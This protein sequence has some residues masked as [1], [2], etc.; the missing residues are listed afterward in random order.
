VSSAADALP[1]RDAVAARR[2][3]AADLELLADLNQQISHAEQEL[4]VLCWPARSGR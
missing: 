3:L 1:T 2:V 4:A